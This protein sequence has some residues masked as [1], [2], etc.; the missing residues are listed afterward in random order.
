[1]Y[2]FISSVS[3]T[4]TAAM[5]KTFKAARTKVL[6]QEFVS[7]VLVVRKIFESFLDQTS[8]KRVCLSTAKTCF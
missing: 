4:K 6:S 7:F 5:M 3:K 8:Q 1:M 2:L